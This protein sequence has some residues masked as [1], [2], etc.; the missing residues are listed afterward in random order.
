MRNL[1]IK[2]T[3]GL[4]LTIQKKYLALWQKVKT[5][6]KIKL[7]TDLYIYYLNKLKLNLPTFKFISFCLNYI[8]VFYFN[9]VLRVI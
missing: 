9:I 6:S 5:C 8:Y 7:K 1:K 2:V 4:L 3:M